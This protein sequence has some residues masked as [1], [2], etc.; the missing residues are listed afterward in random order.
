MNHEMLHAYM[1]GELG[2]QERA[3][4]ES[5]LANDPAVAETYARLLALDAAVE[6]AWALSVDST[7]PEAA[8]AMAEAIVASDR[9]ARRGRLI[10]LSTAVSG[11]AAA[12]LLTFLPPVQPHSQDERLFTDDEAAGYVYWES[13]GETYGTGDLSE[14]E[15]QILDVLGAS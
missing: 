2:P 7:S 5:A 13:D 15:D 9:R 4:V 10:A 12:L 14:L 1:D 3:S 6:S 11:I 8:H